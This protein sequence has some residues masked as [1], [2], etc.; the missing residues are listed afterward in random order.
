LRSRLKKANIYLLAF[1]L[2][3]EELFPQ[4]NKPGEILVH[5]T[6]GGTLESVHRGHL[7]VID[8]DGDTVASLGDPETVAFIRSSSKPLQVMPFLMSGGA[9]S[10]GYTDKEIALACGSHGGEPM[11]T[12]TVAAML[13]KIGLSEKDLR[14]GTHMPF[15]EAAAHA[16]SEARRQPNQLH[17]NCSGKH[18]AMLAFAKHINAAIG[19]YEEPDHPIQ[20]KML[21]MMAKMCEFPREKIRIGVDGCAAPNFALPVSAMARGFSRL[22][23][24]PD[25]FDG[26]LREACRRVVSAMMSC[27]EMVGG[28]ER[29]DTLIMQVLHGRMI[30]KIGAEG[31]WLAGILPCE[32]YKRGLGIGLKIEDGNDNRARAAV[33]LE[34]LKQLGLLDEANYKRLWG[35]SPLAV[36]NRRG[37]IVGEIKTIFSL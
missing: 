24:P 5:V 34:L 3:S 4:Q 11:H 21:G 25:S 28:S 31:I 17:N 30:S 29:L 13:S 8:G 16:L 35:H 36:K 12:E 18:A 7:L 15:N 9:E 14:C 26:E 1:I 33:A 2:M 10:F 37:D 22:V 20:L 32:R 27:P 6:R 23:F 19:S